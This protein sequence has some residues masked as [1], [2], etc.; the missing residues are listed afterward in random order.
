[1]S[2]ATMLD[3]ARDAVTVRRVVGDPIERDGTTV[4][5][6]AAVQGGGGAGRSASADDTGGWG[7]VRARP[8]GAWVVRD[9]DVTWRPALDV[10]R[11]VLGG[12][13]V[14]L[15]L[16]LAVRRRRRRRR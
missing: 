2:V 1:M 12:Q 6:V 14:A 13:V 11:L 4:I 3:Q 16:L 15:G 8:V 9:G 7:W 10:S 5:P